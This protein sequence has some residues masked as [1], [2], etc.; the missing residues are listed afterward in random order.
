MAFPLF[1]PR[2]LYSTQPS[3]HPLGALSSLRLF[4]EV[5][6]AKVIATF[7][8]TE[9]SVMLVIIGRALMLG[10]SDTKISHEG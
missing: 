5:L 3:A 4:N 10:L 9:N 6:R 7:I 8:L 2:P 1:S